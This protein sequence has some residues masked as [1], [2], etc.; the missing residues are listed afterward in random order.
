MQPWIFHPG[1]LLWA[2]SD[3]LE[4]SYS[5]FFEDDGDTGYFYAYDRA[6][7]DA[8]I[9]DAV[10]IY[11]VKD[12]KDRERASELMIYWSNTHDKCALVINGYAHAAFDFVARRGF[13]RTNFPNFEKSPTSPGPQED[14]NWSDD[15]VDWLYE[16]ASI[17]PAREGDV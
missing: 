8:P 14:H 13:C 15:A 3:A 10:F 12:V 6:L 5:A 4:G 17:S 1:D 9:L 16:R 7:A 2:A 11:N